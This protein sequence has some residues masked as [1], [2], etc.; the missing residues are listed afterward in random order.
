MAAYNCVVMKRPTQNKS[1]ELSP[2]MAI[3]FIGSVVALVLAGLI[4]RRSSTLCYTAS[5]VAMLGF[6]SPMQF[7]KAVDGEASASKH[8]AQKNSGPNVAYVITF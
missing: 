5:G 3:W 8:V 1:L 6:W 7:C 4:R 2:R